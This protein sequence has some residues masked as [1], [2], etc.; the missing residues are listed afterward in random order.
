VVFWG[1]L[2]IVLF[3]CDLTAWASGAGFSTFF[4]K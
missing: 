4:L 3:G 1:R 2:F